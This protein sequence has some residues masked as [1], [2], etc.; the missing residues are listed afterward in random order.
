GLRSGTRV[1]KARLLLP[2]SPSPSRSNRK[3]AV[4]LVHF[5]FMRVSY[6]ELSD[7]LRRA[8]L[9]TGLDPD[10]A[11]LCARLIADSTRDG[12]P[13]HGLNL[14]PRLMTMIRSGVVD[15]RARAARVS[16]SGAVER[17]DGCG[18]V[19]PGPRRAAPGAGGVRPPR[20]ADARPSRVRALG[21]PLP[22]GYWKGSGLSIMLDMVAAVLSG[23]RATHE[24]PAGPEEETGVSQVFVAIDVES[25]ANHDQ[26]TRVVDAILADLQVRYPGRRTIDD[27]ARNLEQGIPVDPSAWRFA[28]TCA[29]P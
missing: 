16:V 1:S 27:R 10:R 28:Q 17:W 11:A 25:L 21:R 7:T 15:V 20:A 26:V 2:L 29:S 18:G 4:P 13:S 8:L 19:G 22:I 9:T 3:G 12:V 5:S 14:F 24:V 6:H 23:G